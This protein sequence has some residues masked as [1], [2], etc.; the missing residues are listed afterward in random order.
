M[1]SNGPKKKRAGDTHAAVIAPPVPVTLPPGLQARDRACRLILD[2]ARAFPEIAGDPLDET[3]LSS[4]DAA[5]AH[6]I[7]ENATRYWLTLSH[8]LNGFLKLPLRDLEPAMRAVLLCGA[9]QIVVMDR[10][11]VHAA[12]DTSVEWAKRAIRP[13]AAGMV[14]AVLR[15]VAELAGASTAGERPHRQA[16]S[17]TRDEIPL[18]DGSA[19]LLAQPI[20]PEPALERLGVATSHTLW[21]VSRWAAEL[22]I[23]KATELAHHDLTA[24]PVILNVSHAREPLPP[25]EHLAAHSRAG[26]VVAGGP[27]AWLAELLQSR[28]DAW[29]Q[30]PS[31][32][33]A[34]ESV[35][36]LSPSVVL[37][38][39]AGRGTKTRQLA[40]TFPR[41][42]IIA[43]DPD[44]VRSRTLAE[45]FDG[46]AQVTVTTPHEARAAWA[47]RADLVLLDVPCSNTGVLARRAEA[48]YRC[49]PTQLARLT[50]IQREILGAAPA[51]LAPG[52]KILYSTCSLDR[53][54]NRAVATS[55]E[56][57]GLR[58]ETEALTLPAGPPG[59]APTEYHDGS[60]SA[61][62]SR[63]P[64]Q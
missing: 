28:T 57:H 37:D 11:P 55:V 52:G 56:P 26:H 64:A 18:P 50:A 36:G 48:K 20:L 43:C 62:L 34:V 3:G 60:Y 38:L 40:A 46:S 59:G 47:G 44:A 27:R 24:A 8:L 10:I 63:H 54:E 39:C 13:G 30:D 19:L 16:W 25:S 22:G 1:R 32:S 61:L 7:A 5:F 23:R 41:A 2:R 17:G 45:V 29:A 42:R 51:M 58:V 14:N 31:S 53:D 6:A 15:R 49:G 35:A 9:A 33:L 21:Q 12:I 4:R